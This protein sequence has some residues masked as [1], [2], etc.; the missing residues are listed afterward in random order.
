M[1]SDMY[2]DKKAGAV[3]GGSQG[4]QHFKQVI[5]RIGLSGN[6]AAST[7]AMGEFSQH[8][9][10]IICHCAVPNIRAF[11]HV[12]DEDVKIK[13]AGDPQTPLPLQKS[14]EKGLVIEAAVQ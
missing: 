13:P 10:D 14:M 5:Q 2:P 1:I 6:C 8:F 3:I 11:E 4:G 7:L 12:S 9:G